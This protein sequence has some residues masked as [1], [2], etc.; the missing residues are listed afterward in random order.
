MYLALDEIQIKIVQTKM[1]RIVYINT[2]VNSKATQTSRM[3][4]KIKMEH[5]WSMNTNELT[6]IHEITYDNE[7]A[8]LS[9]GVSQKWQK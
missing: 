6:N 7:V 1:I 5:F 8:G 2:D 3:S 4:I 9:I